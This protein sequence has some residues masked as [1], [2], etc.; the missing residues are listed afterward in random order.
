MEPTLALAVA[1]LPLLSVHFRPGDLM[2]VIQ[3]GSGLKNLVFWQFKHQLTSG[4]YDDVAAWLMQWCL[5]KKTRY[6]GID[7]N[8]ICQLFCILQPGEALIGIKPMVE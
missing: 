1:A 6:A 7:E 5:N 8:I 4:T 3:T 2:V